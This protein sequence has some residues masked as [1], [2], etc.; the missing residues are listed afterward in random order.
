MAT[1]TALGYVASKHRLLLDATRG[2]PT[3]WTGSHSVPRGATVTVTL[4]GT[5]VFSVSVA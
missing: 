1:L 4:A 5:L 3:A 2:T